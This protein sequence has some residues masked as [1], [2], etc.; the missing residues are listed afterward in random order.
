VLVAVASVTVQ[1]LRQIDLVTRHGP[2]ELAALLPNTHFAGSLVCAE[3]LAKA[4]RSL[5]I[6]GMQPVVSM[7]I[8]FYPGKDLQEPQDLVRVAARALERARREG[9]GYVCLVQHQGYLFRPQ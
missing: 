2:A 6:D 8:A 4:V 5:E 3:R 9:P 7:G 1:A